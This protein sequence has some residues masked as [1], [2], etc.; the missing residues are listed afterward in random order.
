MSEKKPEPVLHPP[1]GQFHLL[2]RCP[3]CNQVAAADGKGSWSC[4]ECGGKISEQEES[5]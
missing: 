2:L 4:S 1:I 3:S 5:P